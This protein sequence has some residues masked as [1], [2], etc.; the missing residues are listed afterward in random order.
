MKKQ[1]MDK[2]TAEIIFSAK[3]KPDND[4]GVGTVRQYFVKI[5]Q[6]VWTEGESF[7]GKCPFGNSGWD[8]D[9]AWALVNAGIVKGTIDEDGYLEDCE[10]DKVY[11]LVAAALEHL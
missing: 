7:S 4:A 1:K 11:D 6:M 3:L 10:Y 8:S 2:E 5:A 9:I